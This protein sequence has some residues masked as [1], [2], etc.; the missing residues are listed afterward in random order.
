MT[1]VFLEPR[2]CWHVRCET[3]ELLCLLLATMATGQA[4]EPTAIGHYQHQGIVIDL[5][6]RLP[7]PAAGQDTELLSGQPPGFELTIRDRATGS[8]MSGVY[9]AVWLTAREPGPAADAQHTGQRR[10]RL[11]QPGRP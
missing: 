3:P 6:L 7:P 2:R 9:P 10:R 4:A 8:P 1:P 5:T 11:R